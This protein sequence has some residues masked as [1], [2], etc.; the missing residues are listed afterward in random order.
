MAG[1]TSAG[2]DLKAW[3]QFVNNG[4]EQ[5]LLK[6]WGV[7]EK[8]PTFSEVRIGQILLVWDA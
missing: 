8:S 1:Q 4:L 7:G 3:A 2:L 6:W 5:G